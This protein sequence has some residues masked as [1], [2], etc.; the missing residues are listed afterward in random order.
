MLTTKNQLQSLL[1]SARRERRK[2][3]GQLSWLDRV[4]AKYNKLDAKV[5]TVSKTKRKARG[6]WTWSAESRKRMS[7]S[8]K[9][10]WAKRK[11]Q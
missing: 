8:M 2:I 4:I 6:G 11:S 7:K 5:S 1:Q 9:A 10:S 3:V